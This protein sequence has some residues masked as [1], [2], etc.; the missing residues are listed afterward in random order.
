MVLRSVL[1]YN[2]WMD[3][4][5]VGCLWLKK[6]YLRVDGLTVVVGTMVVGMLVIGAAVVGIFRHSQQL[7]PSS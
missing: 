7:I 3:V 5:F 4:L 1:M 6:W 2:W